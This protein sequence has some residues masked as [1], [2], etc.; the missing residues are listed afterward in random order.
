MVSS[1]HSESLQGRC[2]RCLQVDARQLAGVVEALKVGE[3]ADQLRDLL[4]M[5]A[6]AYASSEVVE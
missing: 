4:Q 3:G 6:N 2:A 5:V 1:W